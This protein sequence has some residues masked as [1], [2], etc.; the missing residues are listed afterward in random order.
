MYNLISEQLNANQQPEL[1]D[2]ITHN[3]I[4][5]ILSLDQ[6]YL[7]Y[8]NGSSLKST[9]PPPLSLPSGSGPSHLNLVHSI[10]P[11]FTSLLLH[12]IPRLPSFSSLVDSALSNEKL[13]YFTRLLISFTSMSHSTSVS[14]SFFLSPLPFPSLSSLLPIPLSF[15]F[16][17]FPPIPFPSLP[18]S[19]AIFKRH[20]GY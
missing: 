11:Q 10:L 18:L 20:T 4:H 3:L 9:P 19:F 16:L 8:L 2:T 1:M 15:P 17:S 6:D 12:F 13:I 14:P 5:E 7:R